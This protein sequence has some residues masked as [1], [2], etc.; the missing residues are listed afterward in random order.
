MKKDD[1]VLSTAT[2]ESREIKNRMKELG[3]VNIGAIKEYEQISTRYEFLTEQRSDILEAMQEL[4]SIISDMDKTIKTKFKE[5]FD[6]G[7][8]K[9]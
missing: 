5:N 7:G 9:L 6:P 1:F 4:Q 3:D 8:R 2:R